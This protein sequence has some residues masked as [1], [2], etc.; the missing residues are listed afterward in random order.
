MSETELNTCPDCGGNLNADL[1]EFTGGGDMFRTIGCTEC[2][3]SA[4]ENWEIEST[5]PHN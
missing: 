3:W 2:G 1:P 4:V 5:E